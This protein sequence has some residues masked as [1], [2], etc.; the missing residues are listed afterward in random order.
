MA[1]EAAQV[2]LWAT[3]ALAATQQGLEGRPP[4]LRHDFAMGLEYLLPQDGVQQPLSRL[5]AGEGLT[6]FPHP[7]CSGGEGQA[8][9]GPDGSGGTARAPPSVAVAGLVS[10]ELSGT[11]IT[12]AK[13]SAGP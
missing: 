1:L 5:H 12:P 2:T 3:F 13:Q 4:R 8:E 6:R 9:A 10:A 7:R 11:A